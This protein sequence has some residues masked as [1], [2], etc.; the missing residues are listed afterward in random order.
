VSLTRATTAHA[1]LM[2]ELHRPCFSESDQWSAEVFAAQLGLPGVFALIDEDHGFVLARVAA[3]EAEILMICVIPQARRLGVGRK[4]LEGAE[5][6]AG[7]WGATSLFLEVST[8]NH[9]AFNLYKS[10]DYERVGLRK[11]YYADGSDGVILR[12]MV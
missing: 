8:Y 11:K 5:R 1:E 6:I 10:R 4:L 12:K 9:A 7:A 3:D 2:A